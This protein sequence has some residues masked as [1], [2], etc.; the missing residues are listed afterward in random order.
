MKKTKEEMRAYKREWIKA[1]R[2]AN[3]GKSKEQIQAWRAANPEAFRKSCL[4]STRRRRA[5]DPE[6]SRKVSTAQSRKWRASNLEKARERSRAWWRNKEGVPTPTRDTPPTCECCGGISH[7][8]LCLDHC[9]DTGKFR[10]WL[11]MKCNTAIGKLGDTVKGVQ[12]ALD[13]LHR[14]Y[15]P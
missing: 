2:T 8:A 12:T 3:P 11:C 1:W 7:A 6:K 13:Y 4:E 9:H 15:A 10:G 5:A 14:A